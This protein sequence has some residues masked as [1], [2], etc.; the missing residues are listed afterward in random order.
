MKLHQCTASNTKRQAGRASKLGGA[1]F[2]VAGVS[3]LGDN[4]R[5]VG[6]LPGPFMI[7]NRTRGMRAVDCDRCMFRHSRTNLACGGTTKVRVCRPA[8]TIYN[9]RT[10]KTFNGRLVHDSQNAKVYLR[11]HKT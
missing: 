8:G 3:A 7:V 5:L 2:A 6:A 11:Q 4:V 10:G 1:V 9:V